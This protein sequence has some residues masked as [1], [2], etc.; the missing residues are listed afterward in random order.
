VVINWTAILAAILIFVVGTVT[1][2]LAVRLYDLH[3]R[4][5]PSADPGARPGWTQRMELLRRLDNQLA[6]QPDQRRQIEQAL[7]ESQERL[8]HIWD[9]FNPEARAEL[10][11][12]GERIKTILTPS[13]REKY[14]RLSRARS[15]RRPDDLPFKD[16]RRD[17]TRPP[18]LNRD[19]SSNAA[20]TGAPALRPPI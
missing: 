8:L 2:G 9:R 18:A 14:D 7:R 5:R 20:A 4:P 12:S 6:L 17:R 3:T 16:P 1:G 15:S 11:Q 19:P 13:Q 10:V